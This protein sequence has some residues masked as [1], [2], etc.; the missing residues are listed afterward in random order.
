MINIRIAPG[1]TLELY[2]NDTKETLAF[3]ADENGDDWRLSSDVT[4]KDLMFF[5]KNV[6][7]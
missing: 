3:T 4:L 2:D 1:S 7:E 6:V 5:M